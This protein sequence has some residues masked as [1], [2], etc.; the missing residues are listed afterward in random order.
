MYV[1]YWVW[2]LVVFVSWH[3]LLLVAVTPGSWRIFPQIA[4][5]TA[6]LTGP[7][8]VL[9]RLLSKRGAPLSLLREPISSIPNSSEAF[10]PSLLCPHCQL[11]LPWPI[12]CNFVMRPPPE[13]ST[14]S[15]SFGATSYTSWRVGRPPG[16]TGQVLAIAGASW[17]PREAAHH[18]QRHI[19]EPP[20]GQK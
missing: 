2:H 3:F 9:P 16:Q 11:P 5:G 7:H 13:L 15:Y 6:C 8:S 17:D 12:L 14:S 4:V 20:A 1:L 10:S 19:L 18:M